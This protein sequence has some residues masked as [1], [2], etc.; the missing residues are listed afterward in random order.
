MAHGNLK[1]YRTTTIAALWH[2]T[3]IDY[4]FYLDGRIITIPRQR[5]SFQQIVTGQIP[6]AGLNLEESDFVFSDVAYCTI[7]EETQD[8]KGVGKKFCVFSSIMSPR[9]HARLPT[10]ISVSDSGA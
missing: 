1:S 3:A 6:I 5:P 2:V 4:S 7:A 10:S 8:P 9:P